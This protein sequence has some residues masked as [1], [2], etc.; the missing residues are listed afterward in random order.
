MD[1]SK[2]NFRTIHCKFREIKIKL[3]I[4]AANSIDPGQTAQVCK[5]AWLKNGAK[6]LYYSE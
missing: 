5:L 6:A 4:G 2:F 1:L 3:W